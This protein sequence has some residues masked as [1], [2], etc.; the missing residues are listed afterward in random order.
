MFG[1]AVEQVGALL[2]EDDVTPS[3]PPGHATRRGFEQARQ[4]KSKAF[5]LK[6]QL[7]RL[8]LFADY[9]DRFLDLFKKPA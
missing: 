8:D 4:D 6:Q 7:D 2:D 5:E 3:R 9:E 1:R